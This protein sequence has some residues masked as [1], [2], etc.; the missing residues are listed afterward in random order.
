MLKQLTD[1]L[2]GNHWIKLDWTVDM[3]VAF[4]TSRTLLSNITQLAHPHPAVELILAVDVSSMHV[5]AVLQQRAS[6]SGLQPLSFFF[7]KLDRAQLKYSAFDR[8]LLAAYLAIRHFRW[9]LESRHFMLES[10]HKPLSFALHR[11]S[12]AWTPLQQRQLSFIA[13]FTSEIKHVPG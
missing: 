1:A 10:D 8:E 6:V 9:A 3:L 5:G 4:N 12:D 13:E 7:C 11:L 2:H